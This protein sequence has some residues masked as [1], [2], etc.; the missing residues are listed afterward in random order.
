MVAGQRE[1]CEACVASSS[2]SYDWLILIDQEGM[3]K[4]MLVSFY[5]LG[6]TKRVFY[7]LSVNSNISVNNWP[8]NKGSD[9]KRGLF[10]HNVFHC[11]SNRRH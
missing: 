5:K 2:T 6:H 10:L 11:V 1:V 3:T 7:P 4:K 8:T 9:D